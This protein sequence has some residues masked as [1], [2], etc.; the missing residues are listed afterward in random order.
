MTP[1]I[2]ATHFLAWA[3]F[4]VAL[5]AGGRVERVAALVLMTDYLVSAVVHTL[6]VPGRHEIGAGIEGVVTLIFLWLSFQQ[7]RWWLM[8][9]GAGLVL[10][11]VTSLIGWLH[12]DIDRYGAVSAQ[13]GLWIVIYLAL[14]TGAGERWLA[15]EAPVLRLRARPR[16]PGV[17]G[18]AGP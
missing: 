3:A 10:S 12:P 1:W 2:L 6:G 14:T 5:A 16:R 18:T 15:G 8:L 13:I 4:V 9:A 17:A 11:C 7:D